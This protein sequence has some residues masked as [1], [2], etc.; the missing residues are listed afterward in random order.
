MN[1]IDYNFHLEEDYNNVHGARN[2]VLVYSDG[3]IVE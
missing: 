1:W 3:Y 2:N